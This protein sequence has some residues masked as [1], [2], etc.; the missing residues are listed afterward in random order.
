MKYCTNRP[1]PSTAC[2]G[3]RYANS[4]CLPVDG[5]AP[6]EVAYDRRPL[7]SVSGEPSAVTIGWRPSMYRRS[8]V[9][10]VWSSTVRVHRTAAG[11]AA[12][13]RRTASRPTKSWA[14][15]FGG[16]MPASTTS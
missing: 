12:A 14:L 13:C 5:D 9:E 8:P 4:T 2:S 16:S 3:G 15:I 11:D 6:A 1:L 7:A 10:E